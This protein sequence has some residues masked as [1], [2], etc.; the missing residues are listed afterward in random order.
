MAAASGT[1]SLS[2]LAWIGLIP[3]FIAIRSSV[4]RVAFLY[5]AL[6]GVSHYFFSMA[7]DAATLMVAIYSIGL[8]TTVPA[9]YAYLGAR[10]T[11]RFGY[12]PLVL[13]V[14]WILVELALQPVAMQNGLLANCV[15]NG[16]LLS[17]VGGALGYVFVAF[18]IVYVNAQL[19]S[20]VGKINFIVSRF[21]LL[22]IIGKQCG[23]I[24][25]KNLALLSESPFS[26]SRPRAPPQVI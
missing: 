9:L 21:F 12:L 24:E 15:N 7:S 25:N 19:I 14:G 6:W 11:R 1:T 22:P 8:L 4:P 2:W 20:L 5:G 3:I 23:L 13:A 18:F 16:S 26:Y 17:I 10:L